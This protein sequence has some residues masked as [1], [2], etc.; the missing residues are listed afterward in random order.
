LHFT[1]WCFWLPFGNTNARIRHKVHPIDIRRTPGSPAT[2]WSRGLRNL[3]A[4]ARL[5]TVRL[6]TAAQEADV[7][8][9]LDSMLG[10]G[11]SRQGTSPLTMLLLGILA[12]RTYQGK[13]RLAD[14][15][16]NAGATAGGGGGPQSRPMGGNA[17]APTGGGL[18][19]LLRGGLGGLLA[20]GAAGGLLSGGLREL[21]DRFQQSGHGDVADS[22]IGTGSNRPVTPQQ[23][24]NALGRDT[25]NTLA[26]EAGV[27]D[28][29]VLNGLSRDLP[30]A[31]DQLT[32]QGRIPE[33]EA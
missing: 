20:G 14:M 15:L 26:E 19:D 2:C 29:D 25:V 11:Q 13:G 28:I 31:V 16:R 27:S 10:G 22:W 30:D 1:P 17:G 4:S 5:T 3:F 7:M 18:G 8:G 21:A 6:T 33:D 23:V 12:Y 9:L 32:P 24:E